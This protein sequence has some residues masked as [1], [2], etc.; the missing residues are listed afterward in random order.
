MT[1]RSKFL[2]AAVATLMAGAA[3]PAMAVTLR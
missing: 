2:V 3:V 1:I